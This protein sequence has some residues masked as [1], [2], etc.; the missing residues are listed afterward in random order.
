MSMHYTEP[1]EVDLGSDPNDPNRNA[2][3]W[4][5]L[6]SRGADTGASWQNSRHYNKGKKSRMWNT[7]WGGYFNAWNDNLTDETGKTPGGAWTCARSF[8]FTLE[9]GFNA[10]CYWQGCDLSSSGTPYTNPGSVEHYGM[11]Y[12]FNNKPNPG[13]IF[14]ILKCFYRYIR[15]GAVRVQCLSS[16]STNVNALAFVHDSMQTVTVELINYAATQQSATINGP[17]LPSMMDVYQTSPTQN[18]V[19]I[20]IVAPGGTVVLPP[21]SITTLYATPE[22]SSTSN[23]FP[24]SHQNGITNLNHTKMIYDINGRLVAGGNRTA[25][26]AKGIYIVKDESIQKLKIESRLDRRQ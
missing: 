17:G 21:Q 19:K 7:E 14:Y 13:P 12:Y 24:Q 3:Y 9:S 16:D 2:F 15:P 8:F 23:L 20:G 22:G 10:I 4:L 1:A 6:Q 5:N 25:L 26:H 18:C 11:M